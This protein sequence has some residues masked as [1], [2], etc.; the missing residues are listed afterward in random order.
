MSQTEQQF[1]VAHGLDG[2]VSLDRLDQYFGVWAILE[3][4]F[5]AAVDRVSGIDLRAHVQ[6]SAASSK[7]ASSG[8]DRYPITASGIAVISISGEMT[9]YGSSLSAGASTVRVRRQIRNAAADAAVRGIFLAIDSP[10][11]TVSGTQDLA[12]D[13]AAAAAKKPLHGYCE[14]LCAS[15]AYWAV[16]Q[17]RRVSANPTALVAGIGTYAVI[18]DSS[19]MAKQKGIKVHVVRAGAF[20]GAG[21]PGTEV[22]PEQLAQWQ[23]VVDGLNDHFVSAVA[24]GRKLSPARARAL[25]D[26]RVHIAADAKA[27]GLVDAVETFDQALA[28]LTASLDPSTPV[29]K[30]KHMSENTIAA[31]VA[32]SLKELKDACVGADDAFITT[33]LEADAT[34]AQATVAWMAEQRARLTALRQEAA[35]GTIGPIASSLATNQSG[36]RPSAAADPI[37]AWNAAIQAKLAAGRSR[38]QAIKQLV[39]E[40]PELHQAYIAAYNAGNRRPLVAQS[41]AASDPIA[42]WN[43]ALQAKLAAG[44]SRQQAI[45]QLVREEPELH[46]AYLEAYNA[47]RN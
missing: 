29:S 11:G 15:A 47:A 2:L 14:D 42:A 12:A 26:G 21:A 3:E 10:G 24:A 13:I 6:Q 31:P 38:Q 20:K 34:V 9:K 18:E 8:G 35:A 17:A 5:R 43:A 27:L 23:R 19:G 28:A 22:T 30:R 44:R 16:S 33:Q 1:A 37:G 40:E 41:S 7:A 46:Q 45:V 4:P 36:A 25:A 32:A 39:R